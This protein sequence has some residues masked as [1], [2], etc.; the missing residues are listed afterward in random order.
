[1]AESEK[2]NEILTQNNEKEL[3][4]F[5]YID[6]FSTPKIAGIGGL[7]KHSFKDF[8]VREIIEGDYV[9][10]IKEDNI[11]HAF[12]EAS[13][14]RFTNFNLIKFNKDTFEA[15]RCISKALNIPIDTIYYSGLKDKCSISVQKVSIKGNFIEELRKLKLKDIFIR[16]ISPSKKPVKIGSNWGNQFIITIRNI[17]NFKNAEN[18]I[19]KLFQILQKKGFPNYYG[20][21]RFGT[22]RPN[23]HLID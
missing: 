13:K 19:K 2:L 5:V 15:I 17:N 12:S 4:R 1:L 7:Y 6:I 8:I 11:N 14:D 9:L 22:F 23:S 16:N 10:D 18:R 21:Q 20:M 3:E